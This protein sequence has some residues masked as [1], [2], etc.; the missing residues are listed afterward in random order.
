MQL[1]RR[2]RPKSNCDRRRVEGFP[3]FSS[4]DSISEPSNHS[5]LHFSGSYAHRRRVVLC[6]TIDVLVKSDKMQLQWAI[7]VPRNPAIAI[8]GVQG[9]RSADSD[10]DSHSIP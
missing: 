2:Q 1:K 8:A 4:L 5:L 3:K 9:P 10:S 6:F 7:Q